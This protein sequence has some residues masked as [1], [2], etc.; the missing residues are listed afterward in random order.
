MVRHS[1]L[2]RRG[3]PSKLQSLSLRELHAEIERRQAALVHLAAER[4]SLISRLM[5]VDSILQEHGMAAGGPPSGAMGAPA[6]KRRGRPPKSAARAGSGGGGA[7]AA[8][9]RRASGGKRPR[10]ATNLVEALRQVLTGKTLSVTDVA[11]AVQDAG[12]KTV[13]PNFRTIVN[14]ALITNRGTFTKVSRGMYTAK[15]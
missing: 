12:Y 2:G 15:K 4:D 3:R 10:N 13:S 7:A 5:E 9:A 14:Q 11:Q 1:K 6:P 8:P